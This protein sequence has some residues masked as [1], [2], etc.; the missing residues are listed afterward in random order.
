MMMASAV[1]S[2]ADVWLVSKVVVT[3]PMLVP[4]RLAQ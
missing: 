1:A 3:A 4:A 2:R